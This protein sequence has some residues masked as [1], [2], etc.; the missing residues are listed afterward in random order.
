LAGVAVALALKA[1]LVEFNISGKV[2]LLGTPGTCVPLQSNSLINAV[3]IL[4]EEGGA[5]KAIL[6]DK[7]AYADMD[8]C[9]MYV[10]LFHTV[11]G[12]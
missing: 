10:F 6:L 1:A 2:S 3:G 4:A 12:S 5:G 7:G 8:I 9:L 11:D